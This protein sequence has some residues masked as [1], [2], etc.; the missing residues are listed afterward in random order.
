MTTA[1]KRRSFSCINI[2]LLIFSPRFAYSSVYKKTSLKRATYVNVHT[3]FR[4]TKREAWQQFHETTTRKR[5]EGALLHV[6]F[7][8]SSCSL[9][10]LRCFLDKKKGSSWVSRTRDSMKEIT[11]LSCLARHQ[12]QSLTPSVIGSSF[13]CLR[14]SFLRHRSFLNILSE[15][16][17]HFVF[18]KMMLWS[19]FFSNFW[20]ESLLGIRFTERLMWSLPLHIISWTRKEL[21]SLHHG[22][23]FL[24]NGEVET[25]SYLNPEVIL[26][27]RQLWVSNSSFRRNID[28][29]FRRRR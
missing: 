25:E 16:E 9:V 5:D 3:R 6:H 7:S 13:L 2:N 19:F 1:S 11:F 20:D 15:H 12:K 17:S 28:S 8:W 27:S 29:I 4:D 21:N 24:S 14:L 18:Q 22:E 23:C 26:C 10:L